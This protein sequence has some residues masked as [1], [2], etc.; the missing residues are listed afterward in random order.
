MAKSQNLKIAIKL[1]FPRSKKTKE[2]HPHMSSS[3]PPQ[4][5]SVPDSRTRGFYGS[6]AFPSFQS[7]GT[8]GSPH[9]HHYH[10]HAGIRGH[11][12]LCINDSSSGVGEGSS[13]S[14][15]LGMQTETGAPVVVPTFNEQRRQSQDASGMNEPTAVPT[16]I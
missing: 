12:G 5:D 1:D 16:E 3:E 8:S 11:S 10:F 9:V 7:S 4:S 15:N 13:G 6:I 2:A 14:V